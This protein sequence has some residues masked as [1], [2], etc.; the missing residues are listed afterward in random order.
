MKRGARIFDPR[1]D[2]MPERKPMFD[3]LPRLFADVERRGLTFRNLFQLRD[4]GWQCNLCAG[5]DAYEF[6]TG[7]TPGEA[8]R[9]ACDR[10]KPMDDESMEDLLS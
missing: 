1:T 10:V 4:G 3:D 7:D 9:E 5:E 6:G 2:T 8:I